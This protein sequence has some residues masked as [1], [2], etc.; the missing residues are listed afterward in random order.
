MA[1]LSAMFALFMGGCAKIE[2]PPAVSVTGL[3]NMELMG[4]TVRFVRAGQPRFTVQAPHVSKVEAQGLLA[5]DG[6]IRVDFFDANGLH[7]ATLTAASGEVLDRESRLLARGDVVVKSDSGMV[8]RTEELYYDQK[9]E[10]VLSDKFVTVIT[11]SD[12]L[13]GWG[14]S[15]APDLTDW[16]IPNP[17]GTTWRQPEPGSESR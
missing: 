6:G 10:R 15:A 9:R 5:L 2:P 12:S 17:S 14:F 7:N 4:A 13:S 11:P 16:I 1:L 3:P 8:L